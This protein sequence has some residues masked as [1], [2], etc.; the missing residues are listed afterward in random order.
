M[1]L[2]FSFSP[3]MMKGKIINIFEINGTHH[4]VV[5]LDPKDGRHK[6]DCVCIFV[7]CFDISL[8][9]G[10]VGFT[11]RSGIYLSVSFSWNGKL[12]NEQKVEAI[13]YRKFF[14]FSFDFDL[15]IFAQRL[16]LS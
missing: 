1:N 6:Y 9:F 16:F 2:F 4:T 7:F 8:L 5:V 15:S 3:L 11:V 10:K 14:S 12:E 13:C